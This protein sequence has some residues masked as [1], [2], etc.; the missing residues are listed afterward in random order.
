VTENASCRKLFLAIFFEHHWNDSVLCHSDD[1]AI[2][3]LVLFR[4]VVFLLSPASI[5]LTPGWM[6]RLSQPRFG[7]T[8]HLY[9]DRRRPKVGQWRS[10]SA[11]SSVKKQLHLLFVLRSSFRG[12]LHGL[13]DVL[14]PGFPRRPASHTHIGVWSVESIV[15]NAVQFFHL[16]HVR[17][18]L[19]Y[20]VQYTLHSELFSDIFIPQPVSS[21]D[22]FD[23]PE[24]FCFSCFYFTC[25]CF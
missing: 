10:V 19:C 21:D 5:A 8:L 13:L 9:H 17:T 20:A 3:G 16:P 2:N 4:P 23:Q 11:F 18:K 12:S 14:H 6:A 15:S 25:G 1:D 22:S 7:C 24:N